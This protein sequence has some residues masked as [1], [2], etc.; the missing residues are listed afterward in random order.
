[1][2]RQ[3]FRRGERV[4][5]RQGILAEAMPRDLQRVKVNR[6]HREEIQRIADELLSD[7]RV[8]NR[9][10]KRTDVECVATCE[11]LDPPRKL[12]GTHRVHAA[13]RDFAFLADDLA[14]ADGTCSRHLEDPLLARPLFRNDRINRRDDVPRLHEP[15]VVADPDVLPRDLVRIVERRPRDHGPRELRRLEFGDRREDSRTPHLHRN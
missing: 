10:A 8:H 2:K 13:H 12:R 3:R 4:H 11:M 6:P 1:M 9:L 14:A 7:K 15:H 5:H